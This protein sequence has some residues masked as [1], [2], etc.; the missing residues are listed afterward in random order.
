[1]LTANLRSTNWKRKNMKRRVEIASSQGFPLAADP[2][3]KSLY[4]TL[5][6]GSATTALLAFSAAPLATLG[7]GVAHAQVAQIPSRSGTTALLAN[8]SYKGAT[9]F[10]VSSSATISV[11][12]GNAVFG[13]A[14]IIWTLSNA[15]TI[16][17]SLTAGTG[18]KL[19]DGGSV[20]NG[21]AASISGALGVGLYAIGS[22]TNFGT[23]RGSASDGV[24][25][26][27][28]GSVSNQG[29]AALISSSTAAIYSKG[30]PVAVGND[31]TI[32]SQN[33]SGVLVFTGMGTITNA[34]TIESATQDGVHLKTG[35]TVTN[36]A[37]GLLIGPKQ[38]VEI[39]LG[40]TVTNAGTITGSNR[41]GIYI[42]GGGGVTN[43]TT[44]T[45]SGGLHAVYF[46]GGAG[47]VTNY[48]LVSSTSHASV[49]LAAGGTVTN[50]GTLRSANGSGVYIS[51]AAGTVT[52]RALVQG[53][54]TG[55]YFKGVLGSV[56]NDGT[57]TGTSGNGIY[58]GGGGSVTNAVGALISGGAHSGITVRGTAATIANAGSIASSG[59][60]G[61]NL[62]VGGNITNSGSLSSITGQFNGVLSQ[63]GVGLVTN[64]GTISGTGTTGI[65]VHFSDAFGTFGNTL[66]DSGTIVGNSGTAV[67]F[68]NGNN[69]LELQPGASL[70]GAVVA[71]SGSNTLELAAGS[72]AGSLTGL[73]TNSFVGFGTVNVDQGAA[74]TFTNSNTIAAGATLTDSGTLT[75]AGTLIGLGS[76]SLN[77]GTFVNSGILT[78]GNYAVVGTTGGTSAV[79]N[80]GSIAAA[81]S[82]ATS[83]VAAISLRSTASVA[84]SGTISST[85]TTGVGGFYSAYG[86]RLIAGGRLTNAGSITAVG[87]SGTFGAPQNVIGVFVG[88]SGGSVS[89]TSPSSIISASNAG[90]GA[91]GILGNGG[92]VTINN[93]GT[94]RAPGYF[95][96]PSDYDQSIGVELLN[97]GII[98]NTGTASL[99]FGG[100]RGVYSYGA[101]GTVTNAG[102]IVGRSRS[103]VFLAGGG[104]VINSDSSAVISGGT[105]AIAIT[106]GPGN[107]QNP[108]TVLAGTGFGI[109]FN[110]GG[111]I[112]NAAGAVISS[113]D[114]GVVSQGGVGVVINAGTI[115]ARG[116][117]A[118]GVYF[119]K[120][121]T[122]SNGTPTG[123]GTFS[124]TVINSGTII[125]NSGAAVQFGAGDDLLQLQPGATF[126]GANG[127]AG[128]VDGAGGSNTLELV[129]G[130][131]A[132]SL[133]GLGTQ[134]INFGTV[135]VDQGAAWT[136]SGGNTVGSGVTLTDRG[137]LTNTGSLAGTVTLA[138]GAVT[139][140][141]GAQIV[142]GAV[143]ITGTGTVSNAGTIS[144]VTSIV[145]A[146][147]GRVANSGVISGTTA[148]VEL[149][150]G[151]ATITNTGTIAA[152]GTSGV[153]VLFTGSANGTVDN[154]GTIAGGS[155]TAVQ[156]AGGTNELIVESGGELEGLADGRMGI[157]TLLFRGTGTLANAQILGFQSTSF[158]GTTTIDGN[159][160]V[161][162]AAIVS[163]GSTTSS[164]TIVGMVSVSSGGTLTSSGMINITAGSSND[165]NLTNSGTITTTGSGVL[166]NTGSFTNSGSV[167]GDTNGVI[168]GGTIS[169]SGTIVGTSGT[170]VQLASG[171]TLTNAAGGYIK[172]GQYGVQVAGGTIVNSGTILDEA[173]A[174]AGLGSNAVLNNGTSGTIGGVVG[175][176]FTGTGASLTNKGT[177]TG[178]GGIAVQFDGGTNV[179]TLTL[180]T[181]SVLIGSIDGGNGTGQINLTGTGTMANAIAHFGTGSALA[182]ASAADWTASGSWTIANVTNGGTFQP[183]TPGNPLRLTGSFVQTPTGTLRVLLDD[184]TGSGSELIVT[185]TAALAGSVAVMPKGQF[186]AA[187]TY[188]IVNAAG[189]VTGTFGGVT[190]GSALLAPSLSYDAND[191]FVT[192]GQQS[193]ASATATPNQR[194]T[195]VAFDAGL[196]ANPGGFATVIRGLD[197]LN[198]AGVAS[199]LDRLSG[200][201]H[202]GLA[203]TALQ[204]GTAFLGQFAQ[205]GVLARLGA[206]GTASGQSA[207]AAG[208]R[209]E[210]ARLDGGSDDPV[211][212]VDKP[213]GVWTSGY[214]QTGQLAGDG[215]A[216]RLDETIAGGAV[217]ADYELTPALRVGAGLGYGGTTFSLDNGGGRAQIDHTQ[218]AFYAGY[219]AGR[220]Y[221]DGTLGV[222][223]GDG[224]TRRN[225]SLPGATAEAQGH[226][227]DTQVLGAVEAGYGFAL[228]DRTTLSPF[229]GVAVGT[230]DQD[231]FTETGAGALDLHVAKQS[232]SS[233]RS[234]L[235]TRL[236]ADLAVGSALVTTDLSVG[237]AHEFA[238]TNRGTTA[239]FVGAPAAGFQVTGAK[240]PGDSAVVG[241][242]LATAL[243]AGTSLYVHYD[244][245][246]ARGATSNAVT[247]GFRFSW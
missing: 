144:G 247:A 125:G 215:N 196:A 243:F 127:S 204:A 54:S 147:G 212:N 207:M 76:I 164:G 67:Q 225:V 33:D 182:I 211:A 46:G 177:I 230:V 118:I 37:T 28:G 16:Q 1:M 36:Q 117:S 39:E 107:V 26:G 190:T 189:G 134:F 175:V 34:G 154:F 31:G 146:A 198:A 120:Y 201:S 124:N 83:A 123:V 72:T 150:G 63:G 61:I 29:S 97:G 50:D 197:Q 119:G 30:G 162:N 45:I 94:I 9:S 195:A 135:V 194:A 186:L 14:P 62:Y 165:G 82:L 193:V 47:F 183:G 101:P 98:T 90:L 227:T 78:S 142:G 41:S 105:T 32:F 156:F 133:T 121:I 59:S 168:G 57:I 213:W 188:T 178:S 128:I 5:L 122:D 221:L 187:K 185:G 80:S 138:G 99:I 141:A 180:D 84:N 81:G 10:S 218:F 241:V 114:N 203:T 217:G 174:G 23:I 20:T 228:G 153:G 232:Q 103:G 40:G 216:H 200:E 169:N 179:N 205:Q 214:A 112:A 152:S 68:G 111:T 77:G 136:F 151:I 238:P 38:G 229:A 206:S 96:V 131:V 113:G 242:G 129:A 126:L 69:L 210:L 161:S 246:L 157:N 75:N 92:P 43:A 21:A 244:G 66:I 89:N 236:T 52:N 65:G 2:G 64:A 27:G 237:W 239:A 13:A 73:G 108:G 208:G 95:S 176:L 19:A 234:T 60:Q 86:V 109:Y 22:I 223:Y 91:V 235:G 70:V 42:G 53:G 166:T 143:A 148:G 199:S 74:W 79:T 116:T 24:F 149:D 55:V 3:L 159:S 173:I 12:G 163:G 192:L 11:P 106:G 155:G 7:V 172:G 170:G 160:T 18:I 181:G 220:A 71:G 25:L 130:S 17:A 87:V 115:N 158:A 6:A 104:T 224:T 44:G 56:T 167:L 233:V 102:S 202:A 58:L 139:N 226:V 100:K 4:R 171:G 48:G 85:G 222:A 132:G 88:G 137:A 93:A 110:R 51:G 219:T 145:L 140:A 184:A 231:G 49:A 15:G 209:Q 8:P 35:G 191:A 245:D 240:V